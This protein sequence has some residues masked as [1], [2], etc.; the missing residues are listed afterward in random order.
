MVCGAI[1]RPLKANKL[2]P[3]G[4][5]ATELHEVPPNQNPQS[6][7]KKSISLTAAGALEVLDDVD[8]KPQHRRLLQLQDSFVGPSQQ[9]IHKS[10]TSL[11]SH[12]TLTS[13]KAVPTS[14]DGMI[15][16]LRK[17]MFYSGSITS[18]SMYQKAEDFP[19]Y[20]ASVT[21]LPQISMTGVKTLS[22]LEVMQ[23]LMDFSIF[24][25]LTFLTLCVASVLSMMGK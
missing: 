10:V 11:N 15:P 22:T 19:S 9:S 16:L 25:S 21:S 23:E 18:L 3:A 4:A 6:D 7:H 13:T 8:A 2:Q 17:D 5:I 24:K 14:P 20:V 12:V 1:F